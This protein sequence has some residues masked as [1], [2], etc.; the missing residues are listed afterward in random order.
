M[1]YA[2]FRKDEWFSPFLECCEYMVFIGC[3]LVF[4][5]YSKIH[6]KNK[7]IAATVVKSK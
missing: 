6:S 2:I 1:I 5:Y 7:W 4:Y 3:Y